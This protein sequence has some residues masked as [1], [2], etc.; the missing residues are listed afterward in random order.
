MGYRITR[1][2]ADSLAEIVS[3]QLGLTGDTLCASCKRRGVDTAGTYY[4]GCRVILDGAYGGWSVRIR[5]ADTGESDLSGNYG[6]MREAYTFL[7]G[8]RAALLEVSDR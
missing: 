2:M 4:S 3:G 7:R 5:H 1:A 6:P 8:M